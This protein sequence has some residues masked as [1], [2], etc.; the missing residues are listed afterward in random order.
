MWIKNK[1]FKYSAAIISVMLIIFL[2]GQIDFFIEPFKKFILI[3]FF[4]LLVS[5][6]LYYLLRPFVRLLQKIKFP[7]TIA[8]LTVFVLFIGL[9]SLFIMYASATFGQQIGS[10]INDLPKISQNV[11][12]Y[13]SGLNSDPNFYYLVG[14]KIEPQVTTFLQNIL[15][16]VSNGIFGALSAITSVAAMLV[17][18]PF[19]LFFLL[20]DDKLFLKRIREQV[21]GRYT[22]EVDKIIRETDKTLSSYIIGQAILALIIGALTYLGFSIIGLKYAAILSLFV[23]FT[24]FIPILG[25]FIGLIP[26][27]FVGF[28]MFSTHPYMVLEVLIL[29]IIVQQLVGNLIFP[30][31]IG[32]QLNIHPLTIILIFLGAAALFGFIGMLIIIPVYAVL[33]LLISGA[34][35]IYKIWQEK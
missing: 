33:K 19:I 28:S 24:A 8:I 22:C 1:F 7:P 25:I 15:P 9:I 32:K 30:N 17:I 20:K 34:F 27:I 18:V 3:I 13:I 16:V 31:L 10:L 21:H 26:A 5:G 35:K 23:A 2:L 12:D 4:P 14:S 6:F 11:I 29:T